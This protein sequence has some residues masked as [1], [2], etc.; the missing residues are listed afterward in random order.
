VGLLGLERGTD[1]VIRNYEHGIRFLHVL[2]NLLKIVPPSCGTPLACALELCREG[3][4][5]EYHE[6]IVRILFSIHAR[7]IPVRM[8]W[9][10]V[11][12]EQCLPF[13][14]PFVEPSD[15]VQRFHAP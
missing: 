8:R 3:H 5:G 1:F 12:G 7:G 13:E 9:W 4:F 10:R 14:N 6:S 15:L 11:G 2:N